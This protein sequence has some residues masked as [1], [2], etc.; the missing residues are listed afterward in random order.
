[1]RYRSRGAVAER[2]IWIGLSIAGFATIVLGLYTIYRLLSGVFVGTGAPGATD[3]TIAFLG[4]LGVGVGLSL[5]S[6]LILLI[7][8][9]GQRAQYAAKTETTIAA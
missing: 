6:F 5:V 7:Q 3:L 8:G 1:M 9:R 4:A 2:S